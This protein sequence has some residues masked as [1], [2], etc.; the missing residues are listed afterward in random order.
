MIS[1]GFT[2]SEKDEDHFRTEVYA[3]IYLEDFGLPFFNTE[4]SFEANDRRSEDRK[5]G[6]KI[7]R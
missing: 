2:Y 6:T 4:V 3:T 7:K 1:L 5:V